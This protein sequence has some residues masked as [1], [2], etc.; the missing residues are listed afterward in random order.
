M[1]R[2]A[3]PRCKSILQHADGGAETPFN[4]PCCGQRLQVPQV[5][6]AVPAVPSPADDLPPASAASPP[7]AEAK[8]TALPP[9]ASVP[10]PLAPADESASPPEKN[11][12]PFRDEDSDGP[13]TPPRLSRSRRRSWD[14][15]GDDDSDDHEIPS[16]TRTAGRRGRYTREAA[17][18]AASAGL[19]FSLIALGLLVVTFVVWLVAARGLRGRAA[20]RQPFLVIALVVVLVSFVLAIVGT[21]FS[22][23]GLDES[24]TYNRGQATTGVVCGIIS[25]VIASL[26]GLFFLCVGMMFSLN[27]RW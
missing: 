15:E 12:I 9:P 23:R 16:I 5:A 3:C 4:C 24:N 2:F 27:G 26:V 10:P 19:V 1:I 21:V 14:D 20:D 8:G 22:T 7:Q 17:A 6:D 13:Q 18:R 25:L 11:I